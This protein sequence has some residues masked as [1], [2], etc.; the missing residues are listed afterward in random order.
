MPWVPELFS[1]PVLERVEERSRNERRTVP[2]FAGML[3]GELD[4]LIGSFAGVPEIH[5][6]LRGRVRGERAFT[7][8]VS[9][10]KDWFERHNASV[11]PVELAV[12]DRHG[13]EEAML[14]LDAERGRIELPVAIVADHRHG[15]KLEELRVYYSN[16]QLAGMHHRRPPLL[17]R[18]P[19]LH[20]HD[21]VGAYQ[22]AFAEGDTDAIL[23]TFEPDG[24]AREPAGN[25]F[26]YSGPDEL[27]AFYD[28]VFSNGGGVELEHCAVIDDGL[29]CALEYNVVRWGRSEL[30]PQAGV[31]AYVRGPHGKLAAARVYDDVDVPIAR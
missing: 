20:E 8:Y 2:F 18:V 19:S 10:M 25:E 24:Y 15:P 31:A 11:E 7:Q 26:A 9:E 1:A 5:L 17:Q 13:C 12:T 23:D 16:W 27:R 28:I 6:P 4:A 30:P 29:V 3:A 14:H 21:V 22:R